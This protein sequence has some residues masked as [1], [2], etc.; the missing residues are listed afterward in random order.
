MKKATLLLTLIMGFSPILGAD[1]TTDNNNGAVVSSLE[2]LIVKARS[3]EFD[4][5]SPRVCAAYSFFNGENIQNARDVH[6]ALGFNEGKYSI[7]TLYALYLALQ[8]VILPSGRFKPEDLNG[9][10]TKDNF[11]FLKK[12]FSEAA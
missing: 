11:E 4:K 1:L 2:Q 8:Q 7:E 10:F 5:D 3:I 9:G 12:I 6:Y